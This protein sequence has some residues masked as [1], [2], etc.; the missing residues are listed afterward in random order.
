MRSKILTPDCPSCSKL[1][2]NDNN[3]FQCN[4]GESKS[5]KVLRPHK[6]KRPY[7][8]RLKR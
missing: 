6:G 1:I 4:W 8:C 3:E 7:F 5:P 2:I